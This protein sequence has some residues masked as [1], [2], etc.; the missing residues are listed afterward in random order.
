MTAYFRATP[1]IPRPVTGVTMTPSTVSVTFEP[2]P[3]RVLA[4]LHGEIDMD[5]AST[6]RA[7]L[8]AAL[9]SSRHGLDV[10]M[11]DITFCDSS[12]LHVLLD[13]N[14]I[15]TGSGKSL[16]LTAASH[17]VARLLEITGTRELF[18]APSR[19]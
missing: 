11:S 12:G 15:A 18:T 7:N 13:L 6:L 1:G 10:D 2:G 16:V 14:K 8:T 17:P 19:G 9:Q 4:R 3:E 5:D